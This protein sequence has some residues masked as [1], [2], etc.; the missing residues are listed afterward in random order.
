MTQEFYKD[1]VI[2]GAEIIGSSTA[3]HLSKLGRDVA[4]LDPDLVGRFSSSEKNAGAVRTTWT[5]EPNI[6]LSGFSIDHYEELGDLVK[7]DPRG[8]LWFRKAEEMRE[9]ERAVAL[10]RKHGYESE[11]I[12][13]EELQ[14]RF[15]L[16]HNTKG[17]AGAT[18]AK[19]DGLI[20]PHLLKE[21]YRRE[22][23]VAKVEFNDRTV[24]TNIEF[25]PLSEYKVKITAL[26][27]SEK[28]N[29]NGEDNPLLGE[30][31]PEGEEVV[32]YAKK[33]VNCAGAWAPKISEMMGV[34][35]HS[36]PY[37]RQ[38]S[39]FDLDPE[40]FTN[41]YTVK[42]LGEM[43][44]CIHQKGVYFQS[45][46]NG[47]VEVAAGFADP[48]EK[49]GIN[50]VYDG[51]HGFF[52]PKIQVPLFENIEA[53]GYARHTGG[54]AGLFC[55]TEDHSAIIGEVKWE[56]V[57]EKTVYEAHSFSG[58]GIMQSWGAGL[59]LAELIVF[60]EYKTLPIVSAFSAS[61]FNAGQRVIEPPAYVI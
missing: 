11:V 45:R 9:A 15:P 41:G 10:Q 43:P 36:K 16:V 44:F 8:Y 31:D 51:E 24:I 58:H 61:R 17:I 2:G 23:K 5:Q 56:G 38:I 28:A 60:G 6:V 47:S 37:R 48:N 30:K 54:W 13:A 3:V 35:V 34:P 19:S 49:A 55:E 53:F 25:Q 21:H 27:L 42:D 26:R 52:R 50:F 12:S 4:V 14:R 29:L 59:S 39:T 32:Y 20:S 57:P 22:A 7:Y 1:I 33:F 46:K 40:A 18:F